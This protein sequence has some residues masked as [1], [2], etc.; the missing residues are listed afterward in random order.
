MFLY[1]KEEPFYEKIYSFILDIFLKIGDFLIELQVFML[2][3]HFT[4]NMC[5]I[6]YSLLVFTSIH[7]EFP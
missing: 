1:Q 2:Y 3:V 7:F 5:E 4:S 6:K